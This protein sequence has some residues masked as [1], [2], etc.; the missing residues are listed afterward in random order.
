MLT[1]T[2]CTHTPSP[3]RRL[4]GRLAATL[5]ATLLPAAAGA[6]P[7]VDPYFD[8]GFGASERVNAATHQVFGGNWDR[9]VVIGGAFTWVD[10][11]NKGGL[12]RFNDDG[13]LDHSFLGETHGTVWEIEQL[14]DNKLLVAG[15][16]ASING[17]ALPGFARLHADGSLDT[18]FKARVNGTVLAVT[19][20]NDGK[21]LVG[22]FFSQANGQ[23]V[24]HIARFLADGTLDTTFSTGYGA[25]SYVTA[26]EVE[27][28][29]GRIV[30]GGYFTSFNG[31]PRSR[32]VRLLP[33][34]AIDPTFTGSADGP[35]KALALVA[36]PRLLVAGSFGQLSG[37]P[38]A[39]L[40]RLTAT[41]AFDSAFDGATDGPVETLAVNHFGQVL[42]GG[43]FSTF[44]GE[45]HANLVKIGPDGAIDGAAQLDTDGPVYR[46]QQKIWGPLIAGNFR[47]VGGVERPRIAQ[48]TD[49]FLS[50]RSLDPQTHRSGGVT[51]AIHQP[52]GGALLGGEFRV[53]PE[54]GQPT[55]RNLIRVAASGLVDSTYRPDPSGPVDA[56]FELPDGSVLVGGNFTEIGGRLR[57]NLARVLPNG[58]VDPSYPDHPFL[59]VTAF[60][61]QADGKVLVVARDWQQNRSRLSRRLPSGETDV[62]FTF[63]P[64]VAGT[65]MSLAVQP[66]GRILVAAASPVYIGGASRHL[67]RILAD[68]TFDATFHA[69]L[70][71]H[72]WTLALLQNG[73]I[74]IGGYFQNVSGQSRPS[75]ARLEASGALDPSFSTSIHPGA[76]YGQIYSLTPLAGGKTTVTG[77][78]TAISGYQLCYVCQIL[79]DGSVDPYGMQDFSSDAQTALIQADGTTLLGHQYG[80]SYSGDVHQIAGRIFHPD[81]ADQT[82]SLELKHLIWR[83]SG[84][85]PE[86]SQVRFELSEDG[87]HSWTLLPPPTPVNGGWRLAGLSYPNP[88]GLR[89]R[90]TGNQ[91]TGRFNGSSTLVTQ[92]LSIPA[93]PGPGPGL[94]PEF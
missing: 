58:S 47:Y 75:F 7:I 59:P 61:R 5:A 88:A 83:R 10:G 35:V 78:M 45:P 41:G 71:H 76:G 44:R 64:E 51:T 73:K 94:P 72:V 48:L 2:G 84:Q 34:G 70:D 23:P 33:S 1:T 13:S 36:G 86:L 24:S 68:G 4:A 22:G 54:D 14:N 85:L 93:D 46:V 80:N 17:V 60:A 19:R 66:D 92:T 50:D 28:T 74:L 53:D 42:I 27:S 37:Q 32:L 8:P 40:G 49:R 63:P 89:F 38:A 55:V 90:A 91:V 20:Q 3:F 29:S 26:I 11:Y 39:N 31:Q 12:A 6:L 79:P 69:D 43:S 15:S 81:P 62:L 65:I 57:R 82:L 67:F 77:S 52:S 21:L 18:T 30:V 16:F 25:D 87:G 56:L 9:K